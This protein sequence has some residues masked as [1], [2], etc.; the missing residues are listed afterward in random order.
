MCRFERSQN[1]DKVKPGLNKGYISHLV[2]IGFSQME[3]HLTHLK[4]STFE[5]IVAKRDIAEIST[6]ASKLSPTCILI[7]SIVL[8]VENFHIL[9]ECFQSRLLRIVINWIRLHV[10]GVTGK[11]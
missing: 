8:F 5:N 4:L 2:S 11:V 3:S 7:Y 10:I 9:S 1:E 6:F